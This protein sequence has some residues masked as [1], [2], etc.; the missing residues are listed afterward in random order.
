MNDPDI[1]ELLRRVRPA[2]P[3]AHLRARVV[4]A[5]SAAA[6]ARPA[7]PWIA[8][9]AAA[10][11]VTATLQVAAGSLREQTRPPA[12]TAAI[13]VESELASSL[14]TSLGVPSE[15]A[16][17]IAFVDGFRSRIENARANQERRDQ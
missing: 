17:M 10:L 5:M 12:A 11:F 4:V 13:D 6:T 16:R 15:E 1:E 8:A 7:W 14:Q 2:G 9:A 3:P